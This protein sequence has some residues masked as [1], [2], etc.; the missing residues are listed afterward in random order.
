MVAM[1][2]TPTKNQ[3]GMNCA[4]V[5]GRNR[6]TRECR[7]AG[8]VRQIRILWKRKRNKGKQEGRGV[9]SNGYTKIFEYARVFI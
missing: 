4:V 2:A 6:M 5:G 7:G 9:N 1:L 3:R 8:V